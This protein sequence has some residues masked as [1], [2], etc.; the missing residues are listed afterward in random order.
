MNG[1]Q[2]FSISDLRKN[3]A[4][5]INNVH[6]TQEPAVILQRSKP[7]AMIVDYEYYQALEESVL[8][9]SDAREAEKA[10]K[11]NTTSFDQ[12]LVKRFGESS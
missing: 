2:T 6:D 11:E 1:T 3:T 4:S 8:D 9:L 12:Y 5:V 7:K 10:K